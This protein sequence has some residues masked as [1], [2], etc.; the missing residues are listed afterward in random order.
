ME[1]KLKSI[2]IISLQL[3]SWRI[4]VSKRKSIESKLNSIWR[5]FLST[6]FLKVSNGKSIESRL[7]SIE[8]LS[9]ELISWR[10]KWNWIESKVEIHWNP[11]FSIDFLKL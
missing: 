4:Q 8:I 11:F 3:I 1:G 10:L 6:D 9:F 7:K 2:E 5:P